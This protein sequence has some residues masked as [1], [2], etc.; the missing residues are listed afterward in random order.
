MGVASAGTVWTAAGTILGAM[1]LI[2]AIS[3]TTLTNQWSTAETLGRHSA[4]LG[5]LTQLAGE[6]D[7]KLDALAG[8]ADQIDRKIALETTDLSGLMAQAGIPVDENVKLV[9]IGQEVI[10]LP[11]TDAAQRLLRERRWLPV[12]ITPSVGGFVVDARS[13]D[14]VRTVLERAAAQAQPPGQ[15]VSPP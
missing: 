13:A 12:Q 9:S 2:G 3:F 1:A 7:R 14:L 15:P 10:A 11:Q 4:A 8:R 6:T 5:T